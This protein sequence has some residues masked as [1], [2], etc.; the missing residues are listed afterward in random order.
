M[1]KTSEQGKPAK[2]PR[3]VQRDYLAILSEAVTLETWREI[4]LAT[5]EKAKT[6]DPNPKSRARPQGACGPSPVPSLVIRTDG[7]N[8]RRWGSPVVRR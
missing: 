3:P 5:V 1:K 8:G 6:G 4:C 2:P 7:A